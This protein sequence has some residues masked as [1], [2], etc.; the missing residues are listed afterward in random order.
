M[1]KGASLRS[2]PF[3]TTRQEERIVLGCLMKLQQLVKNGE[4][5]GKFQMTQTPFELLK[6][7]E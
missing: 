7:K 3:V 6:L 4:K 5:E 2:S 1:T